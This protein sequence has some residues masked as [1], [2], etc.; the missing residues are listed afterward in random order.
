MGSD[1]LNKNG[2]CLPSVCGSVNHMS[3]GA[4]GEVTYSILMVSVL[5][6]SGGNSMTSGLP[7]IGSA[8]SK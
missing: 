5:F 4:V 3:P 7:R 6:L 2:W 8:L 1:R